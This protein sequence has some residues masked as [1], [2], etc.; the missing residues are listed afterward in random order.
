MKSCDIVSPSI[1]E[2]DS[3]TEMT[4][5]Y[6]KTTFNIC[7]TSS[8]CRPSID[9]YTNIQQ[10]NHITKF[11]KVIILEH[12]FYDII[13]VQQ[14][15]TLTPS[16]HETHFFDMLDS[17]VVGFVLDVAFEGFETQPFDGAGGIFAW[18]G[19]PLV[20]NVNR[21]SRHHC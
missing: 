13:I 9:L 8:T 2:D 17:S 12:I 14:P 19:N 11:N 15:K 21:K 18:D 16:D 7:V 10:I 20:P 1:A 6:H 5:F 3:K 4:P